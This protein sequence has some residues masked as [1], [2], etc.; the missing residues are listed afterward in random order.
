MKKTNKKNMVM[1][2]LPY[3]NGSVWDCLSVS[4]RYCI[5]WMEVRGL[6][7]GFEHHRVG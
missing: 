1:I 6:G 3:L 5:G 2:M 4:V 7:W